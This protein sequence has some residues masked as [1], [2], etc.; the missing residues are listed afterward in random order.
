MTNRSIKHTAKVTAS[1]LI[2]FCNQYIQ[3]S[4]IKV[5]KILCCFIALPACTSGQQFQRIPV[6]EYFNSLKKI[7]F[8]E[9]VT[10]FNGDMLIATSLGFADISAGE[11]TLAP[12]TGGL[13][14]ANGNHQNMGPSS[15]FFK[16]IF[17][18]HTGIKILA[19]GPGD[20]IYA[21]TDNNNLG[22]QDYKMGKGFGM[23]PFKFPNNID[24]RKIW[25]DKDGDLFISAADSFYIIREATR[26]YDP[27]TKKLLYNSKM[28][29]NSNN[30]VTDGAK[31]IDRFSFG[32]N[33][34]PYCFAQNPEGDEIYIGTDHGLFEFDKKTGLY[35]D[36]F[37]NFS[38]NPV[39]LT[40]IR[41]NKY[42]TDIWFSTL[43]NGMGDYNQF[44]K[45]VAYYPYNNVRGLKSPV[46]DFTNISDKEFLVAAADSTPAI[47]NT[48]N[49]K[50]QFIEDT[51]FSSTKNSTTEISVG[52]GNLVVL[53]KDGNLFINKDFLKKRPVNNFGFYA[54]PSIKEIL[55][56]GKSYKDKMNYYGW[57]DSL[58]TIHFPYYENDID[59]MYVPRGVSS[60]ETLVFAWKLEGKFDEWIEVPFTLM[61]DR[62]NMANF[63][64]LKPG[65]YIF[66]VRLK[67]GKGDWLKNEV[68]LTI[69][70][71]APFW[72]TWWFWILVI[73]GISSI[74]YGA[75]KW[76]VRAVRKQERERANHEK[77]LSELEARALRSQMNPHF[78]F[79]C[80]NSIKSLIQQ[81]EEEKSVNY[82]TTFSKL[83]RTLFNN[84][85]KKEISLYDEIETCKLYLQ[86]EAMRFNTKFSYAVRVDEKMD[87]KSIQVPALIIQ[88]FIENAIWHGIVPKGEAGHVELSV[89]KKS[90]LVEI[91]IDDNGIG[92]DASKQNKSASALMHNSKGVNLTQ[93]RLELDNL[94]RQREAKLEIVDKKDKQGL[95]IGTK[96]IITINEELS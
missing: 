51:S 19:A 91:S 48:E 45:T 11:F 93:S 89:I 38:S 7:T 15:N 18:L 58:K 5:A 53:I 16:D 41:V 10:T 63:G 74:T 69:I 62:L 44:S 31:R 24:I 65:K 71:D 9:V 33:I 4:M 72:K 17:E 73:I 55:V 78:V 21:V 66:R 95:A 28:D 54:G 14:D 25:I 79:N 26:L 40:Q 3:K 46:A 64:N 52:A 22:W 94:L 90:N 68:A 76:R 27:K 85:D 80:L 2:W 49:L 59:I 37:K 29:K 8:R 92:R 35:Y 57:Y 60:S 12:P 23:P 39:T 50:Y 88:P 82:L 96:V 56:G 30:I 86:L 70:I 34:A 83:I 67:K 81:H 77:E 75:V 87:L 32:K 84:A 43:E 13:V 42:S 47:F 1:L 6:E 36:L 20:I 61:E